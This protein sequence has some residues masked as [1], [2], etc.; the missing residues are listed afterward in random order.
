MMDE[1]TKQLA[2]I[3]D[4]KTTQKVYEDGLSAPVQEA[5]GLL[6]DVVKTARLFAAP[7]QVAA[8]YQDRFRRYLDR[9]VR[10]VPEDRQIPAPSQI[11]GPIFDELRYCEEGDVI[12]EMYLNL[13]TKA[14]D[15][16]RTDEAH[17]AFV[18]IIG[19]LSPDEVL[20]LHLL[21]KKDFEETYESDLDREKNRF[22]NKRIMTREFP[23]DDLVFPNN[24]YVYTSHLISLDLVSFPVYR[25]EPTWAEGERRVQTGEIG[26]ARLTLTDF[27]RM[28][29]KA[30]EPP[31]GAVTG[32]AV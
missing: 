4:S 3:L 30:C 6:T 7:F 11:A 24:Y 25:Q 18:K 17:P 23:I 8:A 31:A 12:A 15:K 29:V 19:F 14:I 10:R 21:G 9:V 16:E 27:G 32:G 28:F 1:V 13:L 20:M 2:A 26:Y 22:I 5:G